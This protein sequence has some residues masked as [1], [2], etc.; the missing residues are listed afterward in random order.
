LSP[1]RIPPLSVCY[2][3][4]SAQHVSTRVHQSL[5]CVL[6]QRVHPSRPQRLRS[7]SELLFIA[8]PLQLSSRL[9]QS[10]PAA[11]PAAPSPGSRP[12]GAGLRPACGRQRWPAAGAGR[13]GRPQARASAGAGWQ[14]V[15]GRGR[16]KRPFDFPIPRPRRWRVHVGPWFHRRATTRYQVHDDLGAHVR[17]RVRET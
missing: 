5:S 12:G 6:F 9:P 10:S 11:A 15:G 13:A 17:R 14:G 8:L 1:Q 4:G 16:W 3:L 7:A 2:P